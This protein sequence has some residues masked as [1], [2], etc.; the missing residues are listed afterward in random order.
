[1]RVNAIHSSCCYRSFLTSTRRLACSSCLVCLCVA[2]Y[3]CTNFVGDMFRIRI[4]RA[5]SV[6]TQVF[7]LCNF[8]PCPRSSSNVIEG[9]YPEVNYLTHM[10]PVAPELIHRC[11][12]PFSTIGITYPLTRSLNLELKTLIKTNAHRRKFGIMVRAWGLGIVGVYGR[13]PAA[14]SV[15][16]ILRKF[17]V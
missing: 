2:A 15:R 14:P 17:R 7:C 8:D 10:V 9:V 16:D 5:P 3:P 1:M 12:K 4:Q 11:K 6:G 13:N